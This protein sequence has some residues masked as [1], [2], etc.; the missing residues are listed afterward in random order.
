MRNLIRKVLKESE[1]EFGWVGDIIGGHI[2]QSPGVLYLMMGNKLGV[3]QYI[4]EK[5]GA[6]FHTDIKVE[7]GRAILMVDDWCDLT[8]LFSNNTRGHGDNINSY[9]AEKLFCDEDFWEPYYTGDLIPRNSN[10]QWVE[11]IWE[12]LVISN[13]ETLTLVLDH[14]RRNYVSPTNY[15]PKQLDIY[16]ELP[17]KRNVVKINNRVLDTEYFDE[18][19]N[20]LTLLG[21]LISE[22]DEFIDLRNEL[23]WAYGDSYNN[24]VRDYMYKSATNAVKDIFG[25]PKWASKVVRVKDK[26]VNRE[27]MEFDITDLFVD[28]VITYF[29]DCYRNCGFNGED[30]QVDAEYLDENCWECS[31]P[32]TQF[33][34]FRNFYVQMANEGDMELYPRFQEWP[35][36]SD[37]EKYFSDNITD[38]I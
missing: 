32:G 24:V 25:E 12:E 31:S 5:V 23:T 28:V 6:D 26:D 10:S 34:S 1:E 11:K 18:L 20:N 16:G 21:E 29:N 38:R 3:K 9:L 7:N 33:N 36:D 30:N 8:E 19:R 35:D 15:N 37:L 14:I 17:K 13:K 4:I 27:Y 2:S 22:E